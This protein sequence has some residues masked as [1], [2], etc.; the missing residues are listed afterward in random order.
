LKHSSSSEDG[1]L[2][3]G[4]SHIPGEDLGKGLGPGGLRT[5]VIENESSSDS[6]NVQRTAILLWDGNGLAPGMNEQ[7]QERLGGVV[8]ELLLATTDNHYVN[9]KPGG[10]NPLSDC[11]GLL[12]SA[13]QSLEEA[14]EDISP[15]EAA[16]GTVY[17]GG[18]EI[19]GQGKQDR[20]SAAA[21]AVVEVARYSW[22]PIYSSATMF[23]IILSSYF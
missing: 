19:L 16:M 6:S 22:I 1:Y 14:I 12:P 17:V 13:K 9:V 4:I 23:C 8:D 7:L 18:V 10:F 11:E 15:A 3:I 2:K 21:N 5:L 20:I